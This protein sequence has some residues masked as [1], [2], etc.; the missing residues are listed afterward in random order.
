MQVDVLLFAA[1]RQVA[2]T[3]QVALELP[4]QATFADLKR[5]L[6]HQLPKLETLIAASRIAAAGEFVA[7]ESIVE[8]A[9]EIALIPP[10]SGG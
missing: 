9:V 5:V 8:P 7:D 2:A 10:V 3:N 4:E 6:S 1:A